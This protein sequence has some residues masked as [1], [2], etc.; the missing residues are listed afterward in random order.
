MHVYEVSPTIKGRNFEHGN[1][2]N[3]YRNMVA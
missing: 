1:K 2:L 3:I